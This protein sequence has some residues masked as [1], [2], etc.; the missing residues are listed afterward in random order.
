[1]E[2]I[3]RAADLLHPVFEQS[4]GA[5][6]FVSIEISPASIEATRQLWLAVGRPNVLVTVP[7]TSEGVRT[8][9]GLL[10]HGIPVHA[11]LMF[12]LA[13]YEAM[14]QAFLRG[15]PDASRLIS[16]TS[17]FVSPVDTAVDRALENAGTP[18]ALDLRGKI[19]MANAKAVYQRFREIFFGAPFTALRSRGARP[20]RLLWESTGTRNPAY[21]DV[22]YVEELIGAGTTNALSPSTLRAFREHGRVRGATVVEGV[23]EARERLSRL[24]L[25][26]IDLEAT[27]NE[28][29]AERVAVFGTAV[30]RL[31]TT[32][33]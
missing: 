27:A 15:A 21:S 18:T 11:T 6:G 9:Q 7:A 16:A 26:G 32:P 8:I 5:D 1:V 14:A 29:Q 20:P 17:F 24:A 10:A 3:R 2:D 22:R 23:R 28:L 4:H 25:L 31:L 19:A 33:G 30:D 13:H 12:S